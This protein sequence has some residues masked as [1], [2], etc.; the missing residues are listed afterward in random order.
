M[1]NSMVP[2]VDHT[3]DQRP[4]IYCYIFDMNVKPKNKA[5]E[6]ICGSLSTPG[7][8]L[9][10]ATCGF[11]RLVLAIRPLSATRRLTVTYWRQSS[12]S[13]NTQMANKSEEGPIFGPVTN[14]PIRKPAYGPLFFVRTGTLLFAWC[15]TSIAIALGKSYAPNRLEVSAMRCR[16][17]FE[18]SKLIKFTFYSVYRIL[19]NQLCHPEPE[20]SFQRISLPRRCLGQCAWSVS[21][22][23]V[24][25]HYTQ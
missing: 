20:H 1:L 3:A 24:R 2:R 8:L 16:S 6:H 19:G 7:S 10:S 22:L 23:S 11:V 9:S 17:T 13:A 21:V 14:T 25:I 12:C 15:C 5:D 4:C 18:I